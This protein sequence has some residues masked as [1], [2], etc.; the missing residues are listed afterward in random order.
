MKFVYTVYIICPMYIT[1]SI[2]DNTQNV[3]SMTIG[4]AQAPV[5]VGASAPTFFIYCPTWWDILQEIRIK[6][7]VL[8]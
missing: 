7:F 6:F 5:H 3:T 4:S 2:K 1:L 8:C